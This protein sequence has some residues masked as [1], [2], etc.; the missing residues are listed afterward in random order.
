LEAKALSLLASILAQG[1]CDDATCHVLTFMYGPIFHHHHVT[2]EFHSNLATHF[3]CGPVSVALQMDQ[4]IRKGVLVDGKNVPYVTEE[5]L[6]EYVNAQI[7]T[8]MFSGTDN[9]VWDPRGLQKGADTLN[10]LRPQTAACLFFP[11]YSHF[12]LFVG[13]YS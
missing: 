2:A 7:P 12:D 11:G 6:K 13:T 4:S 10:R 3:G 9:A 5:S 8:L 1:K